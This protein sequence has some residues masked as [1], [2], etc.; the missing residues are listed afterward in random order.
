MDICII[1]RLC[2]DPPRKVCDIN[3]NELYTEQPCKKISAKKQGL[4][5]GGGGGGGRAH[6]CKP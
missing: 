3:N 1:T 5:G 2:I 4:F 6:F